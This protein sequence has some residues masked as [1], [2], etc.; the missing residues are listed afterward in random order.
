MMTSKI[1]VQAIQ[2]FRCGN[3]NLQIGHTEALESISIAQEGHSLV[4]TVWT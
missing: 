1:A 4:F 2:G 3:S